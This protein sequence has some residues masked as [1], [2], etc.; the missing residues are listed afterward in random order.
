MLATFCGML[1]I[2]SMYQIGHQYSDSVTNILKLSP[3]HLVSNIRHQDRCNQM[4]YISNTSLIRYVRF[5]HQFINLFF[6]KE[7]SEVQ[8]LKYWFQQAGIII[9]YFKT[10]GWR[11]EWKVQMTNHWSEIHK[12]Y[13]PQQSPNRARHIPNFSCNEQ[14]DLVSI[15]IQSF[16]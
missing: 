7:K 15:D 2:F 6:E 13:L 1:V 5:S 14:L 11:K 3:T 12:E 10:W 4:T 9:R 16:P 8:T